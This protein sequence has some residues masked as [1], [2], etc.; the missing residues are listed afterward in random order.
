MVAGLSQR[1]YVIGFLRDKERPIRKLLQQ[2]QL[3]RNTS[4][5]TPVLVI[6]FQTELKQLHFTIYNW[7]RF[8][9]YR[10]SSK[11]NKVRLYQQKYGAKNVCSDT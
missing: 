1:H 8:I 2:S 4:R 9:E 5:F 7:F 3:D 11:A 6:D 10:I